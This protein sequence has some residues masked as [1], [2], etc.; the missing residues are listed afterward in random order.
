MVLRRGIP[1]V[2]PAWYLREWLQVAGRGGRGANAWLQKETGW[3][4]A[5]TSQLL[6]G[7]QDLDSRYIDEAARALCIEKHELLMHPDRAMEMRQLRAVA[8]Q[9]VRTDSFGGDAA[10]QREHDSFF[11]AYGA[12]M[13]RWANVEWAL[14][15]LYIVAI[16]LHP[17]TQGAAENATSA[18]PF[19]RCRP[20]LA[21]FYRVIGGS[22]RLS[23]TD[24]A[25]RIAIS[26]TA[27]VS[28][29]G[30]LQERAR[31]ATTKRNH[32]A[33]YSTSVHQGGKSGKRFFLNDNL[34]DPMKHPQITGKA[35]TIYYE[36][37]LVR[38]EAQ[39]RLLANNLGTFQWSLEDHLKEQ[40]AGSS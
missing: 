12:A 16:G 8:D 30:K 15:M 40:Q 38:A 20:S 9:A 7:K 22:S 32:L 13:S 31:G 1:K 26:D 21:A 19:E 25:I 33:H 17:S 4:K 5:T 18:T 24:A 3:S 11:I 36:M 23:M 34:A 29:W 37:D 35:R 6:N 28:E 27:L 10:M 2:E 39:F 14:A